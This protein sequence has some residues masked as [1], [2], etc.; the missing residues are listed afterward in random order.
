MSFV[1]KKTSVMYKTVL[2]KTHC[3]DL[4]SI[5]YQKIIQT[6]GKSSGWLKLR[7]FEVAK[8]IGAGDLHSC[9]KFWILVLHYVLL[10]HYANVKRWRALIR[11]F[12]H[13]SLQ[14]ENVQNYKINNKSWSGK[15]KG[16]LTIMQMWSAEEPL[17]DILIK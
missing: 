1:S 6:W 3:F 8:Q 5:N 7:I 10:G 11:H 12:D 15:D 4:F 14:M 17:F 2:N 9:C 13:R 16:N